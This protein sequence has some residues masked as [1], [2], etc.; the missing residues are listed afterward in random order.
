[1]PTGSRGLVM[2]ILTMA[3]SLPQPFHWKK[4][5][6]SSVFYVHFMSHST[7]PK[8]EHIAPM[9][10][11]GSSHTYPFAFGVTNGHNHFCPA[12]KLCPSVPQTSQNRESIPWNLH[13]N[14]PLV[15]SSLDPNFLEWFDFDII[16]KTQSRE[17]DSAKIAHTKKNGD[18]VVIN[19]AV[20][21]LSIVFE[22][23][24]IF[25]PMNVVSL[26]APWKDGERA[27]EL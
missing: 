22:K 25:L 9:N 21:K 13:D 18:R 19:F 14:N 3:A 6:I 8:S 5:E 1:M 16:P 4:S 27:G 10:V 24:L 17:Y 12:A 23:K 11:G 26:G 7:N 2:A 15:R 20:L